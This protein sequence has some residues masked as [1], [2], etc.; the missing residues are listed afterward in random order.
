[1]WKQKGGGRKLNSGHGCELDQAATEWKQVLCFAFFPRSM[2]D[3]FNKTPLGKSS[4]VINKWKGNM[5]LCI[6]RKNKQ[7]MQLLFVIHFHFQY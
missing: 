3:S 2:T 1:M 5:L 4:F 7:T 6:K